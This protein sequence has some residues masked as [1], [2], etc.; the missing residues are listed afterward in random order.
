[1]ILTTFRNIPF[2][3]HVSDHLLQKKSTFVDI[4]SIGNWH[5]MM[6]GTLY[7]MF[8]I[9]IVGMILKIPTFREVV[10]VFSRT[11]EGGTYMEI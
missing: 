1:M 5:V 10:L 9:T 4:V 8:F 7:H 3:L 2:V 11:E 6:V